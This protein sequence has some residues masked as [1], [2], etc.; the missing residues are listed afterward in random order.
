MTLALSFRYHKVKKMVQDVKENGAY[1]S[2]KIIANP[3]I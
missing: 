1:I 3:E 2:S